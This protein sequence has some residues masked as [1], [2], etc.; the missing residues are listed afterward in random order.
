[1][2]RISDLLAQG[3]TLSFEFYA[4][5]DAAGEKRLRRTIAELAGLKPD[6]MSVTYGAGGSSRGP[7]REWVTYIREDHGITAMPHLTCVSHTREEVAAIIDQYAADGVENILALR[8]DLPAGATEAPSTDF[9]TAV[10]LAEFIRS[11]ADFDIG[12]AAH[13]EGHP[14]A[15]SPEADIEHQARKIAAADFAIT[16]F[17]FVPTHYERFVE[18]LRARGVETPVIAGILPPTNL[19]SVLRMSKMNG[20]EVPEE[21]VACLER[22]GE[23]AAARREVGVGAARQ[24]VEAAREAGAPGVHLYTMNLVSGVRSVVE[25]AD[26][27][28]RRP[29]FS[30]MTGHKA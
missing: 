17:F 19:K 22:A 25:N 30:G 8:G 27:A 29:A 16:Q 5:K 26:R 15:K 18:Q 14:L 9:Q 1:M 12:V 23:D 10:E 7:T 24:V 28:P 13:P 11:R 2:A 6:F 21:I 4:P 3:R 20:V